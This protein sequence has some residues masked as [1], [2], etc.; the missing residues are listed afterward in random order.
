MQGEKLT[1][2]EFAEKAGCSTQR[3]YQLLKNRLKPFV[4]EEN[5]KKFIYE[6]A[7]QEVL[8][9]RKVQGFTKSLQ[10]V[11]TLQKSLDEQQK[12]SAELSALLEKKKSEADATAKKLSET[13]SE[14]TQIRAELE[15]AKENVHAAEIRAAAAAAELNAERKRADAAEKQCAVKDEQSAELTSLLRKAQEQLTTTQEQLTAAQA[16]Q[17]GVLQIQ[18]QQREPAPVATDP[19]DT[20]T[21]SEPKEKKRGL[22]SRLFHAKDRE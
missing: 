4:I 21:K 10:E 13:V 2:H 22:F 14:L 15:A 18:M 8:N 16:L 19:A 9:A 17:A 20:Q 7:V 5:G 3:V 12:S 11:E 1:I 6:S